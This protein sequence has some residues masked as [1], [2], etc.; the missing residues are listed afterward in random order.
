[1][2]KSKGF[3]LVQE[4]IIF[5]LS[6]LLLVGTIIALSQCLKLEQQALALQQCQQAAQQAVLGQEPVLP[7]RRIVSEQSGLTIVELEV[8][9]EGVRYKLVFA[10]QE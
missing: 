6:C 10:E 5:G 4:L 3:F 1:M 7:V 2:K 8:E 9:H